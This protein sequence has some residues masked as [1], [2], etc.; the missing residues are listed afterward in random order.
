VEANPEQEDDDEYRR[1]D[2]EPNDQCVRH[3]LLTPFC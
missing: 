2:N 1:L 3:L